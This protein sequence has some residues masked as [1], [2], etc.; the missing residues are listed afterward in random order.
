MGKQ[1]REAEQN[2]DSVNAALIDAARREVEALQVP[3]RAAGAPAVSPASFKGYHVLQEV[4]RGGQGVVYHAIEESTQREVAIK[5]LKEGPLASPADKAR[6]ERE[7]QILTALKHPHIVAIRD[8]GVAAGGQ[9]FVTDYVHGQPLDAYVADDGRSI[10]ETLRVFAKVCEAVNAAHLRGVIHRDLKPGN[11]RIDVDGEPHILDFGLAKVAA[12]DAEAS[13]MTATGQF[14]GSLPWASPEQAAG[15][16]SQ[17]DIRTDVYSLGVILY[18]MLTDRFP[19]EVLGNMHDVLDRIM[20]ADPARPS[21]IRRQIS[22]EV[23]TIVL[24][25]LAKEPERRYQSAGELARDVEHYL[26][27]EPITAKRDSLAYVLRKRLRKNKLPVAVAVA[28]LIVVMAGLATSLTFWRQTLHERDLAEAQRERAEANFQKARDAVDQMLT[29]VAEEKLRDVPQMEPVRREL[30]EEALAFY[31]GFLQERSSDPA[32]RQETARAYRRVGDIYRRLAEMDQAEEAFR[33]AIALYEQLAA[34]YPDAPEY[35]RDLAG[36][37]ARLGGLLGAT[38]RSAEA[39]EQFRANLALRE[40]LVRDYPSVAKYR[41]DLAMAHAWRGD[42]PAEKEEAHGRAIAILERLLQQEP[43]DGDSQGNLAA[44]YN[45]LGI[46]F[47]NTGRLEQ[48]EVHFAK[49]LALQQELEDRAPGTRQRNLAAGLNSL[50]SVLVKLGRYDE[51]EDLLRR[52]MA[53]GETRAAKNPTIPAY[54]SELGA[55]LNN[56]AS[57]L[58][59]TGRPEEARALWEQAAHHQR[60]ALTLN[61]LNRVY[62][63]FLAN[64]TSNLAR[65]L[66]EMGNHVDAAQAA[67]ELSA[68]DPQPWQP[69]FEAADYLASCMTLAERDETLSEDRRAAVVNEYA[70]QAA[71]FLREAV[72]LLPDDAGAHN[73]LAWLLATSPHPQLRDAPQAVELA[74]QAVELAPEEGALWNTLGVARYRAG[75]WPGAIEALNKSIELAGGD[76]TDWFFLAMAHWQLGDRDEARRWYNE[77]IGWMEEKKPADEQLHRF[78]AEAAQLLELT[79]EAPPTEGRTPSDDD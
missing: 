76:A 73:Q 49:A 44:V 8:S 1:D 4:H 46:L 54:Q 35:R 74:E 24:K 66:V 50:G 72:P 14:M 13:S 26:A 9:Y 57:L 59:C 51:A 27:G 39:K 15:L 77:A 6:F 71:E 60:A 58:A 2:N 17:I 62:R 33:Q 43:E 19:Y 56:L 38:A 7:V 40:S 70:E 42:T 21:T 16:P 64:H 28:F 30:L 31:Q 69:Y 36:S 78:R 3:A 79:D 12:S 5:L 75:N 45:S 41:R 11:I 55:Q 68:A 25:S 47:S 52:A 18:Q 22:N 29:R 61:P 53:I 23:E 10:D 48:A 63:R 20:K 65:V 37:H 34:E 32:V 67:R